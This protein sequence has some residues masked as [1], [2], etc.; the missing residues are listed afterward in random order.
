MT[1]ECRY[2][3]VTKVSFGERDRISGIFP[4]PAKEKLTVRYYAINAGAGTL[5]VTDMNGKAVISQSRN[6]VKGAQSIVVPVEKLAA[7]VYMV[8]IA[9]KS[10]NKVSQSFLRQ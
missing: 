5:M 7:G 2:T 1:S 6:L 8:T 9:D 4:Q 10:G 3:D